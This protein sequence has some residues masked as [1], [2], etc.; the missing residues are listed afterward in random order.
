L[1]VCFD[2]KWH[3]W[4]MQ[5]LKMIF[6]NSSFAYYVIAAMLL[7]VNKDFCHMHTNMAA[8]SCHLN[9]SVCLHVT[10]SPPC[11]CTLTKIS[12]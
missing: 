5:R 7:Y 11:C 8:M 2:H 10:S 9:H 12:R 3:A 4:F 6:L 1:F